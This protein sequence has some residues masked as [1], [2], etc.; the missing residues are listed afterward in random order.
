MGIPPNAIKLVIASHWHNDHIKGISKVVSEA[1]EAKFVVSSALKYDEFAALLEIDQNMHTRQNS[2]N[3]L[4]LALQILKERKSSITSASQDKDI[5]YSNHK[6]CLVRALSPSDFAE[7]L[8][9]KEIAQIVDGFDSANRKILDINPNHNSIVVRIEAEDKDILLGSNLEETGEVK[10]GWSAILNAINRS[11]Q[12]ASNFKVAHHG[13]ETSYMPEVW[14]ELLSPNPIAIITPFKGGKTKL[15]TYESTNKIL[16]HTSYAYITSDPSIKFR[17][18][19]RDHKVEKTIKQLGY[20]PVELTY[21][22]GH[23]RLRSKVNE[24]NWRMELFGSAL[25]LKDCQWT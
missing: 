4:R 7:D 6:N 22:D 16:G 5:W 1:T 3:E 19:K 12:S 10:A 17:P 23:V 2:I 15:P 18:K 9:R 25:A 11:Q 13:S 24:D 8:A 20:N 14:N 21:P